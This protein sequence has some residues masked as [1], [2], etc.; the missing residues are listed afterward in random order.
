MHVHCD[1]PKVAVELK[2]YIR[3]QLKGDWMLHVDGYAF[4]N[5]VATCE[6]VCVRIT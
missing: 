4:I 6:E 5:T 3:V 2:E 1:H